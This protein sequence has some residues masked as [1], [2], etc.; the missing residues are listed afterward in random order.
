[1]TKYLYEYDKVVLELDDRGRQTAR[2]VYG[3]NLISRKV[4]TETLY[5]MYNGHAD[6]TALIDNTGTVQASYY[7]DAF[8]TPI[9]EYTNENG[10]DNPIR[11][12]GYQ[13]DSETGLYYLNAR[14]YDSKIARF[15]SEDTYRGSAADPLSL[16]LYTYCVNNPIRY[17]DPSGHKMV[18]KTWEGYVVTVDSED[19]AFANW[20]TY[21]G[22]AYAD[23]MYIDE[24]A[25]V[26]TI[27]VSSGS[28]TNIN[29]KGSIG[30]INTGSKSTV[31]LYN[32]G[33]VST[34]NSGADSRTIIKNTGI[35]GVFNTGAKSTNEIT[36]YA[37]IVA[38]NTGDRNH[39]AINSGAVG[40]YVGY[41]GG[42][43]VITYP[44]NIDLSNLKTEDVTRKIVELLIANPSFV[45][46][47]KYPHITQNLT[48]VDVLALLYACGFVMDSDG[49]Y[50]ARQEW[51]IQSF[52][53]SG[54]NDFYDTVFYYATDMNKAK[55]QFSD[56]DGNNY[57][58]WAW[59]GCVY[60]I[61]RTAIPNTSGQ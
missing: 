27:N 38:V 7:Y 9:E 12:A 21:D 45:F 33:I 42:K 56:D 34:I 35:I 36:N 14:Y 8:G 44:P 58:F 16:N 30:T 54:F 22:S 59:K 15:L 47:T 37:Y 23:K 31:N 4:E 41:L 5:Y 49:I 55:F 39:T 3:N 60:R 48:G 18:T 11:Y 29:N 53:Y 43:G 24:N 40:S 61:I 2:N 50:H 32:N 19:P 25:V 26:E 17:W 13:Y 28:T 51:S 46:A 1:M 10:K 57:I 52:K 20:A 6:V